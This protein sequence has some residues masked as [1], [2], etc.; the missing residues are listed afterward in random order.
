[1]SFSW[2]EKHNTIILIKRSAIYNIVG[3]RI[4]EE[5]LGSMQLLIKEKKLGSLASSGAP[6]RLMEGLELAD[7]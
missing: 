5:E 1:M 3:G 7:P 4:T 2:H 6:G